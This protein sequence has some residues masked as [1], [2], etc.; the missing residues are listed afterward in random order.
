MKHL[1]IAGFIFTA[2]LAMPS[3]RAQEPDAEG[4]RDHPMFNRMPKF[5]INECVNKEF[6]AYKFIVEN[7][8]EDR[9]KRTTVEGKYYE[10][11]YRL[12]EGVPEPSALQIFRNFENALKQ[13]H[14][15]IV[16]KVV[17]TN[18]SYSFITAKGVGNGIETW[19]NVNASGPEYQLVIVEKQ[20]MEQVIKADEMLKALND[21]GFIALNILFDTAKSTIKPESLPLI[22]QIYEML[23]ANPALKVSI[24]GHTDSTGT[25]A[26]NK[27][28]SNARAKAVVAA[29]VAKGIAQDRLSFV[30]WG[31][32][33]PVADNRTEEGKTKNRRVE[34]VK[35]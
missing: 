19:V 20:L 35:K 1:R 8:S 31:Q 3:L 17:E 24:E 21:S 4:C 27:T 15:T 29:L 34:I 30:G 10:L 2:L 22:D 14:A 9:A 11:S 23:Q 6:D 5:Y 32:D 33:K 25:P 18:N 26:G 13:A 28:L 12:N 16:A 7:S